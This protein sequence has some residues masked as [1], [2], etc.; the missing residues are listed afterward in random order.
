MRQSLAAS[1]SVSV[2]PEE[3]HLTENDHSCGSFCFGRNRNR[4]I[5]N[6]MRDYFFESITAV[7][8]NISSGTFVH[9][10]FFGL[11]PCITLSVV[12]FCPNLRFCFARV[13]ILG[14]WGVERRPERHPVR[15]P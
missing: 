13:D 11:V 2:L 7:M 4:N 10:Q 14:L 1:C 5:R 12:F 6:L 8:E 15:V 9:L 3:Y